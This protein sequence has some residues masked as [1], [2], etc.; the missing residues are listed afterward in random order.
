[1]K[2]MCCLNKRKIDQKKIKMKNFEK[3]YGIHVLKNTHL[4]VN[5]RR[6]ICNR[7]MFV[8]TFIDYSVQIGCIVRDNF[9][10]F[11]LL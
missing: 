7:I 10:F 8:Y 9:A 1:M 5:A 2:Q 11:Y 4:N 6:K 3:Y